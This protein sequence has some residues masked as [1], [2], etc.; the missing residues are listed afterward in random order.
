MILFVK[1]GLFM[2]SMTGYMVLL[3]RKCKLR[4]EFAPVIYCGLVSNVLFAAGILNCMKEATFL[5]YFGGFALLAWCFWDCRGNF[6]REFPNKRNMLVFGIF[7]F[8]L[9]YFSWL[10]H[11]SRIVHY[12]NFSHWGIVVKAMLL[13]NRMPNFSDSVIS[14]QAYPLGSSLFIYYICKALGTTEA[15]FLWGQMLILVSCLFTF[16]AF[17]KKTNLWCAIMVALYGAYSFTVCNS[18]YDL[19]VDSLLPLVAVATIAIIMYYRDDPFRMIACASL[20]SAF[21]VNIKN[22]G[23]FFYGVCLIFVLIYGWNYIKAHWKGSLFALVGSPVLTMFLWHKHVGLV[24][25]SANTSKH[26][27]SL[28]NYAGVFAGKSVDDIKTIMVG[29]WQAFFN[30]NS[31]SMRLCILVVL[32]ALFALA[33]TWRSNVIGR[34][35]IIARALALLGIL[36]AWQLSLLAM[37]LFSM[38]NGEALRLASYGRYEGTVLIFVY[39]ILDIY[40]LN[41]M[42]IILCQSGAMK[43]AGVC[44]L[45]VLYLLPAVQAHGAYATLWTK[46]DY[47]SSGRY[48]LTS[49]VDKYGIS[50]G[51][52]YAIY[53][54]DTT[55]FYY[56]VGK[57]EF[58][59]SDIQPFSE[60]E[61]N[62][63]ADILNGRDYLLVIDRGLEIRDDLL[64]LGYDCPEEDSFAVVL[65][66]G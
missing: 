17:L 37:Y 66:G 40:L 43:F 29:M 10:L 18:I 1:F 13:D 46:Q 15:C 50:T 51:K 11:G 28:S 27:M 2:L 42:T 47:A 32:I 58:W 45:T 36:V 44:L 6:K 57:Y 20:L 49:L 48:R 39:G 22:S 4:I 56:Y 8:V 26:A 60:Y 12:D 65:S 9:V 63:L 25:A 14:F 35:R 52:R 38:P 34:K 33:F 7:L 61:E 59:T 19:L 24:F 54:S 30:L 41:D 21:L 16:V 55:W 31:L 53:S 23:I 62:G 3:V 5:L 64:E